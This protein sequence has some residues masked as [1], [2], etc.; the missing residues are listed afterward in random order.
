MQLVY[1]YYLQIL[2]SCTPYSLLDWALLQIEPSQSHL[3]R[4]KLTQAKWTFR[5]CFYCNFPFT[6]HL[7]KTIKILRLVISEAIFNF[8]HFKTEI[9]EKVNQAPYLDIY[10]ILNFFFQC[11]ILNSDISFLSL[12][13]HQ[14]RGQRREIKS[15]TLLPHFCL[16]KKKKKS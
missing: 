7:N 1:F 3:S 6:G 9:E 10:H 4:I 13:S 8:F 16:K 11:H 15:R 12:P 14:V 2:L 5:F